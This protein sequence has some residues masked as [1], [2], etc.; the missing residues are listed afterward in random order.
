LKITSRKAVMEELDDI[1]WKN[2]LHVL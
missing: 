2:I 1:F